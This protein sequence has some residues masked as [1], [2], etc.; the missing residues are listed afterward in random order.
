M[1][2]PLRS[3]TAAAASVVAEPYGPRISLTPL[4]LNWSTSWAAVSGFEVSSW[5]WI[6]S[7]TFLP[8]TGTPPLSLTTLAQ[9]S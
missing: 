3:M 4:S 2:W 1:T 5:Y 9:T 8:P 7:L 6:C